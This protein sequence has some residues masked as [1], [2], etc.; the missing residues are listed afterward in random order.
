MRNRIPQV[1]FLSR[2]I[3]QLKSESSVTWC[4]QIGCQTGCQL[5]TFSWN[6]SSSFYCSRFCS[7]CAN[8]VCWISIMNMIDS[9]LFTYDSCQQKNKSEMVKCQLMIC[10]SN[11][12]WKVGC[13]GADGPNDYIVLRQPLPIECRDTVTGHA[14]S[15][16]CVDEMTW[17]LEDKSIWAAAMAMSLAMIHVNKS[18][19]LKQISSI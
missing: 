2:L 13:C 1:F 4:C 15:N 6:S 16:G 18:L 12:F 3:Y 9:E 19:S 17:Y 8:T 10:C 5:K 7:A 11:W 14:F